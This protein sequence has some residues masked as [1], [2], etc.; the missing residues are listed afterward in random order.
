MGGQA[1]RAPAAACTRE[2]GEAVA[3]MD[4]FAARTGLEGD[5]PPRR[6]LWTD[7]FGVEN[8]LALATRTRDPRHLAR[9]TTLIDQV[10]RTLGSSSADR[11]RTTR[12][13]RAG[14]RLVEPLEDG[15]LPRARTSSDAGLAAPNFH[16]ATRWMHALA[17][18]SRSTGRAQLMARARELAFVQHRELVRRGAGPSRA[19]AAWKLRVDLARPLVGTMGQH[20]ALDGLVTY[21]SL[22]R[23]A[24]PGGP[25][26]THCIE[27]FAAMIDRAAL[28]TV[29]PLGLGTL[30]VLASRL[31]AMRADRRLP[32]GSVTP[33][34]LLD[35]ALTGLVVYVESGALEDPVE[36]RLA[37]RELGLVLG[38]EAVAH[39][40]LASLEGSAQ[41]R[42]LRAALRRFGELAGPI[43]R[44]WL[45]PRSRRVIAA[46]CHRDV[47][48]VMLAS[49]LL[50]D[51]GSTPD[52]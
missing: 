46:S 30:L 49:A 28:V 13:A 20:D 1:V 7:A 42:S 2:I 3:L 36:R 21:A 24:T 23:V 38:I 48:E 10:E 50:S 16:D 4:A 41:G 14:L 34:E 37:F 31:E 17:H 25:S 12:R 22:E 11:G 27:D 18:A 9:A 29:D 52:A 39:A 44:F 40:R 47:D 32:A 15:A 6:D 35:A 33:S 8:E 26:L 43:T 51:G 5:A 19:G 45:A